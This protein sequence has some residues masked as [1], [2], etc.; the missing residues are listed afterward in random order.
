M[1]K[2]IF[3]LV[4]IFTFIFPNFCL[5]SVG[6]NPKVTITFSEEVFNNKK[7][8]VQNA[9]DATV[10][11]FKNYYGISL[12]KDVTIEVTQCDSTF[13]AAVK[14]GNRS[15]SQHELK[16]IVRIARGVAN[17]NHIAI[18]ALPQQT[19]EEVEFI[20]AHE[21]T[22]VYNYQMNGKPDKEAWLAEG[23]AEYMGYAISGKKFYKRYELSL[24]RSSMNTFSDWVNNIQKYGL[25]SSYDWAYLEVEKEV[26]RLGSEQNIFTYFWK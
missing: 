19:K 7:P 24:N 21:L 18:Y 12:K 5:A 13:E 4:A 22:H 16:T 9:V 3:T 1:K 8:W 26:D 25:S 11:K 23:L 20:V 10:D 15:I 6:N 14:R 2:Y 17:K